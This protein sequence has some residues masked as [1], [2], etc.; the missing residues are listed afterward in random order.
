MNSDISGLGN[1]PAG[2]KPAGRLVVSLD[3]ELYWGMRH[4]PRVS[5][6]RANLIGARTAVPALLGL[7][8]EFDIHAT[9]ATVGFLFLDGTRA[10]SRSAPALKP[11]YR[12]SRLSP[13]LDL[14]PEEAMETADSVYFAPSLIRLI[15]RSRN[16]EIGTHTFSHYYCQEVGAEEETFRDD[17]RAACDAAAKFDVHLKSLVF[18]QNECRADFLAA[19][20]DAGIIAYRGNPRSWFHSSLPQAEHGYARRL[21]RLLDSYLPLSDVCHQIAPWQGELPVNVP[22]SQLLRPYTPRLRQCESL[23]LRRIKRDLSHAA[24]EGLLYH[25]WWHPHNFGT[26]TA[27]N[28]AFLRAILEHFRSL[29]CRYGMKSQ[30]MSEAAEELITSR[31]AADP[32]L[33]N[34][35]H[36]QA[37]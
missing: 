10:L 8:D 26:N 11:H 27:V 5:D 15:A 23:R 1:D 24:E 22:A 19:C 9:W 18:P 35:V 36:R 12:N 7:F 4:L 14:P 3:F 28:L 32:L 29:R 13:Y 6:Y 21:G 30:S 31:P 25:L 2:A 34:G 20:A 33:D 17:L 16:Q 37:V